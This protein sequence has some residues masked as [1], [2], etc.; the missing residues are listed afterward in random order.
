MGKYKKRSFWG[1]D[2]TEASQA[3]AMDDILR[4]TAIVE[5]GEPLP[6]IEFESENI[7]D[8]EFDSAVE[9]GIGD[10][11]FRMQRKN[12]MGEMPNGYNPLTKVDNSTD[13]P[14]VDAIKSADYSED[15]IRD[16]EEVPATTHEN[17][18]VP[19]QAPSRVPQTVTAED[20]IDDEEDDFEYED[21][22]LEFKDFQIITTDG[23][24][25]MYIT[26]PYNLDQRVSMS[27]FN[28]RGYVVDKDKNYESMI[29]YIP[30][31]ISLI[32][33]PAII[34]KESDPTFRK[35]MRS[36]VD[37][38]I[39]VDKTKFMIFSVESK[40]D[41][42]IYIIYVLDPGSRTGLVDDVIPDMVKCN[43]E[44][45][46]FVQLAKAVLHPMIN[47]YGM[48]D[49]MWPGDYASQDL[50]ENAKV[51][52]FCNLMMSELGIEPVESSKTSYTF[53]VSTFNKKSVIGD[54]QKFL[55]ALKTAKDVFEKQMVPERYTETFTDENPVEEKLEE[56]SPVTEDSTDGTD[57]LFD[58]LGE[59]VEVPAETP[60]EQS[61]AQDTSQKDTS[62]RQP[63]AGAD[64]KKKKFEI[65]VQR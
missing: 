24:D 15:T 9:D 31:M 44:A 62:K 7:R 48:I 2:V 64:G 5:S 39:A 13:V 27:I 10:A 4:L 22:A 6:D 41:D 42:R 21:K 20:V 19:M 51:E 55:G 63:K 65:P 3:D 29:K 43:E 54:I 11:L 59:S 60:A 34:V 46:F 26:N 1:E 12:N 57:G 8:A 28:L 16:M 36:S 47:P 33:G 61:K 32:S 52:E 49:T 53:A 14:E 50:S 45:D 23:S 17:E 38:N 56:P 25:W 40:E 58:D 35:F 30:L 37:R 18:A